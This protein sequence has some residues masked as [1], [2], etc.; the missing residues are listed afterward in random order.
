MS[1]LRRSVLYMPASNPRALCKARELPADVLVFDLEDAVAPDQKE[2][3]R[4]RLLEALA[5]GGYGS[6]ELVV[7][8]NAR[9]SPWFDA[10]VAAVAGSAAHALCLPKVEQPADVLAVMERLQGAGAGA[11]L[12]LWV[13][14]ETP[15]GVFNI[16]QIAASHSRIQ[17]IMLGT[18]DLTVELRARHTPGREPLLF[19][20]S[21]CIMA[22]R[23]SGID[24]IDGVHL[25]LG[26]PHGLARACT[27]GR[28]LGFDGKSLIHPQQIAA[29][30]AAFSPGGEELLLARQIVEAWDSV[31]AEGRGVLVLKG[32]LIENLHVE[33]ALRLLQLQGVI[34]RRNSSA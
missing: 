4:E 20:L 17:V 9:A 3:A 25:E 14:A 19:A 6:R 29:A 27:E 8:V 22:A 24:V 23:E 15:R 10:D 31:V 21:Q 12:G 13:M 16:R 33:Q 34:D 11:H 1:A 18:S 32:K 5:E 2:A 7:R 28:E 26:D 30:N